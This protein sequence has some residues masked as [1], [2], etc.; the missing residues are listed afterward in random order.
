MLKAAFIVFL[1]VLSTARQASAQLVVDCLGQPVTVLDFASPTL[2]SGTALQPGAVYRF[3]TVTP[4]IDAL[5]TILGT[6]SGG[7]LATID[8]DAGLTSYFQPELTVSGA[9]AV[10][11]RFDFV[12]AGTSVPIQ[13]NYSASS[14]DVDGNNNNIRE[15]V[16]F[17][18]TLDFY[19][20]DTPTQLDVNASGPSAGD[21]IRFESRT[22]AVA[23]GIDPT[24]L[25]NIVATVHTNS[26]SFDFRIGT[27][28][29]G[30]QT[31]LTSLGFNCPS[32]STPIVV[33]NPSMSV[34]K[35]ADKASVTTVGETIAYT[36]TVENSGNVDLTGITFSDAL[37]QNGSGLSL[38]T[39]P[40]FSGDTDG[41][42]ELDQTETWV[43]TATYV[44]S[45]AVLNDG[46]DIVNVATL[47]SNETPI[48]PSTVHTST[49]SPSFSI[50][51]I[52]DKASVTT[53]GETITYTI[54]VDNTGDLDL[55]GV[56]FSD[57]LTQNGSGLS[58]TTGPA[59][60]GDSDLDG[61]LDVAE[62]WVYT[63][64]YD[65]TQAVLDDGNDI[66]N[67]ATFDT[68]ETASQFDSVQ[69]STPGI[70]F[71]CA[72]DNFAAAN[73]ISGLSGTTDCTNVGATGESGEPLTFG[74]GN[75]NTIWYNWSAPA[76][77]TATFDTCDTSYTSYDTTLG[78]FTGSAVSALTTVVRND[79]GPG[80][81]AFSS[82]LSFAA[83]SGTIYRIQ[84][85]GYGNGT[86]NFRLRWNMVAPLATIA[87]SVN[88]TSIS[89]TDTLNYTIV[90]DNTGN[91]DLTSPT[92]A[93]VLDQNGSSLTLTSGPTLS[94]DTD[95]DGI[96]DTSE[97]WIYVASYD[98]VQADVDDGNDLV[99]TATFD[100]AETTAVLDAATTT[101]TVSP[102][103]GVAKSADDDTDVISGQ[104]VTY[105]YVVTN[106][107]NQTVQN[108]TLADVHGGSGP[109]PTPA[110]EV[111]SNDVVPL[112][113]STDTSADGSWDSLAPG[114]SVTFTATYTVTQSDIDTLQ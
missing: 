94:G 108:I 33:E 53:D 1:F 74:G 76:T 38:T 102:S 85:G 7:G 72:G 8:N 56:S 44:V 65:V 26:S 110:G 75:L 91:V 96:L 35:V 21:R 31:R 54:T 63:A 101:I 12:N 84:V 14:I 60:S 9:G 111:L 42:S 52:A 71:S 24:A 66:I 15:Y 32:L 109:A 103:I 19:F 64:T 61:E 67:I 36:I 81:S 70:V 45:A 106:N 18:T 51:K 3:S 57:V 107:G 28:G 16:E 11:F 41:D 69:T 13:L 78:V 6:V 59:L 77:G 62:T 29:T 104:V 114:D 89:S 46:N 100:S 80:C 88:L 105:T 95:G 73:N 34:T 87:K 58:L 55:T 25:A 93:D 43:Y 27:L 90:V 2:V 86:G 92:L 22:T 79:D 49:P 50:N 47:D 23:P 82:L 39:G 37:S 4:G 40:F 30:S 112:T 97:T 99:N 10:D 5:V 48:T 113:D 17:E 83:V 98:V 20:L 68:N